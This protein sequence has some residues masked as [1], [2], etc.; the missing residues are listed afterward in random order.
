MDIFEKASRKK[1]RFNSNVGELTVEQLWDLSLTRLD[2]I[3]RDVNTNLKEVTEESFIN[4]RP[5]PSKAIFTLQLDILKYI[6][7][8]KQE[9]KEVEKAKADRAAKR[10]K[11][12]EAL[13][14]K[15]NEELSSKSK[16]D[17]LKELEELG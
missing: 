3:A 8:V 14:T 7:S 9:E 16:E 6:I 5:H 10:E 15:E 1:V 11:L 12:L 2:K 13:A 4:T 17:I